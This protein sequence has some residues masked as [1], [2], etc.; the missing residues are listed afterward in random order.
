MTAVDEAAKWMA[1]QFEISLS[2]TQSEAAGRIEMHWPEFIYKYG[3]GNRAISK[4]VLAE[5]EKLTSDTV[6]WM[7]KGRR[8]RKRREGDRPGREQPGSD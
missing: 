6:V 3:G 4:D 2:L 8:W 7:K 1:D 5:F